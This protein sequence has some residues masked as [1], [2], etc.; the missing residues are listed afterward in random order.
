MRS[1]RASNASATVAARN[2]AA[3]N[4]ERSLAMANTLRTNRIDAARLR[5]A[6]TAN[7]NARIAGRNNVAI[8]RA[9]N[10]RIVNNW[11]SGRF[12]GQSYA[13]F[14]DYHR[15]WHKRTWWRNHHSRIIFVSGGWWYWNTGYW[16][17]LGVR[18]VRLLSV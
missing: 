10:A 2:R 11:R 18:S 17:G 7:A 5:G 12:R 16:S 4:R 15:Q 8:N 9:R 13:A 1:A 3:I 6:Q 14:R